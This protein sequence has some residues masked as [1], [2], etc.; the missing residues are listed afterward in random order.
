M[1]PRIPNKDAERLVMIINLQGRSGAQS[2]VLSA[3]FEA[4]KR[5]F[6]DLLDWDV[7]VVDGRFEIDQFDNEDAQYLVVAEP[8][9]AHLASAR[10]L[11]TE[12]PHLLADLFPF[13][14]DTEVPRGPDIR[15]I[16]RFCLDPAP[17]AARRREVRNRL[18]A[19]LV[20][21]ALA[22]G[23]RTYTGVAELGWFRQIIGFGWNCRPLGIPR[24]LGSSHITA[25]AI[26][27]DAQTPAL[28][29]AGGIYQPAPATVPLQRAA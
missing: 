15:E 19:A 27:I 1:M 20:D 16:T 9:G 25:L 17:S 26:D 22:E 3:M 13:L 8:G 7:P 29:A 2:K 12:G 4:R 6:V 24:P 18:I 10:L 21:H 28:L 23:I 5:V 14:C 11:P